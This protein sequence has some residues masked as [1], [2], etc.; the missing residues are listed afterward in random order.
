M[1]AMALHPWSNALKDFHG[2]SFPNVCECVQ[3][4]SSFETVLKGTRVTFHSPAR[5]KVKSAHACYQGSSTELIGDMVIFRF[6]ISSPCP[7]QNEILI[8]QFLLRQLSVV[9]LVPEVASVVGT[10]WEAG[11]AASIEASNISQGKCWFSQ[12]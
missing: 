10:M 4:A 2:K 6:S 3:L 1:I 8:S 5:L 9:S 12:A 7:L 11:R